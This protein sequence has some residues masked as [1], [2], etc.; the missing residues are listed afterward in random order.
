MNSN[1]PASRKQSV[2]NIRRFLLTAALIAV[3]AGIA[4]II[5]TGR[6]GGSGPVA[7]PTTDANASTN[8]VAPSTTATAA[9]ATTQGAQSGATQPATAPPAAAPAIVKPAA[10]ELAWVAAAP[11]SPTEKATPIGSLDA[12][13]AQFQLQ[14]TARGAGISE[15]IFSDLWQAA[16]D[17]ASARTGTPPAE[18]QY[19]LNA[20]GKLQ[21]F[22]VPLLSA[23]VLDVDGRQIR[24]DGN[25]WRE[26]A[27]G[28]FVTEISDGTG[29]L[30][31]RATRRWVVEP[32]SITH[33]RVARSCSA[34]V[35]S[36]ISVTKVPGAVSRQT[37]PST[38]ICRPSTSS[39]RADRSGT[40]KP[41]NFPGAVNT[42]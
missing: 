33:R 39:T 5:I 29:A 37:L 41:C 27:P 16:R 23:R 1:S 2:F 4:G 25:V 22:S 34:P 9:T 24:I 21:G 26:T 15:I 36:E 31:L 13:V 6:N 35:P 3:V 17:A 40:V 11:G 38:R 14:L 7:T 30:Q 28:T 18:G 42:Y 20:P 32:G 10:D 8:A 12:K 19:V